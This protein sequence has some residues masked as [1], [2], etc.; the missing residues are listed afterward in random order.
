ML[1]IILSFFK[2][3]FISLSTFSECLT[4]MFLQKSNDLSNPWHKG[5]DFC[6]D[7]RCILQSTSVTPW[8]D[9]IYNPTSAWPLTHQWT[10]AIST[11]TVHAVVVV[12]RAGA[13]HATGE[14][15]WIALLTLTLAQHRNWSLLEGFRICATCVSPA[16]D[17]AVGNA[18]WRS[19]S[20]NR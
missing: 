5:R 18:L 11:A 17:V 7:A 3:C 6:V 16:C 1:T 9:P 20:P 15:I 14:L 19:L 12:G 2:M 8:R 10:T 13:Q 4:K